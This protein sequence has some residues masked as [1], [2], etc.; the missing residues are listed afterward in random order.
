MASYAA[1]VDG[2]I[3]PPGEPAIRADDAGFLL[4]LSV[5]ETVLFE[6]G[7]FDF[8]E[9]HLARM[10]EGAREL[11]IGWPPP[12]DPQQALRVLVAALRA[13]GPLAL[14]LT[15]SR[16]PEGGSPTLAVT[17][18]DVVRPAD[19]GVVVTLAS[20][21]RRAGDPLGRVK[22][23]SRVAY[24]LAREEAQRQGAYEALFLTD[25]DDV[26]EGTISNVFAVIDGALWTPALERGCLA[27]TCRGRI[28]A[29]LAREPAALGGRELP[30]HVGRI[31]RAR[32]GG[33]SEVF[34]TNTTG[35]V[36]PVVLVR[37][38]TGPLPGAAG[39]VVRLVRERLRAETLRYRA[40][41]RRPG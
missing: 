35:G 22:S 8:V 39:P 33:A 28:L 23:S 16:G 9:D 4:G 10:Q 1:F 21:R 32:L 2:R 7:S 34:L 31:E 20:E 27:G 40:G 30:V 37:G 12:C 5:F 26:L 3:V 11:G 6:E 19:P 13:P 25:A 38:V 18:R 41:Q 17:A 36:L 29:D 15:L 14:R 24:V